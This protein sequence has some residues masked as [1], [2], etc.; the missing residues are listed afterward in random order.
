MGA[1]IGLSPALAAGKTD[2]NV[3]SLRVW[4]SQSEHAY[5]HTTFFNGKYV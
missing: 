4:Q 3:P 1:V 5:R 2:I